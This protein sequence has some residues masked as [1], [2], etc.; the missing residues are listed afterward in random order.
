VPFPVKP[1]TVEVLA[2]QYGLSTDQAHRLIAILDALEHDEYAPTAVREANQAISVHI[3]DSLAALDL[4]PIRTAESIA[5][6]GTGAGFPGLALAVALPGAE[7]NLVESQRRKCEFLGRMLTAT[8]IENA[9]VVCARVE[10]W[11]GGLSRNDVVVARALAPPPVVLEYAAPVLRGGGPVV[12][13]RGRRMSAEEQAS[14]TA[15]RVLG[16]QLV[17]IRR[18]QPFE[19]A[20]DRHLH[21]FLKID[22][23][24]ERFPRRVGVARKR[25]LG[26]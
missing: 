7:V 3:A 22:E 25:P 21:V 14:S 12:D 23:T 18:V 13:W 8:E 26:G 6:L 20:K 11:Q 17:E 19:D 9:Q 16:L 1:N 4:A 10:E 15:A 5:D 24:S 2:T